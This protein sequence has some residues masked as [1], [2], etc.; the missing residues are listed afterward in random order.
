MSR[1][2][3]QL[4]EHARRKPRGR[5]ILVAA[6][7][8]IVLSALSMTAKANSLFDWIKLNGNPYV[9]AGLGQGSTVAAGQPAYQNISVDRKQDSAGAT[10][11]AG[12]R[13][14]QTAIE[15]GFMYLPEYHAT[16]S[17]QDYPAYKGCT[18]GP[19]CPQTASVTQDIFA[20]AFYLRGNLYTPPLGAFTGYG[21]AGRALVQNYNHEHGT[22]NG[23]EFV[24]F[25]VSFDNS[26]WLYGLGVEATLDKAWALRLEHTRI[27]AA[28]VEEHTLVRD[29]DFT[30]VNMIRRF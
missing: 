20:R 21:F 28:T 25:K 7:I 26:A 9:G 2:P 3:I 14:G 8:A 29:V 17:T 23:T 24:D 12:Y 10:V 6:L 30:S 13:F 27:P 5:R 18:L 1:L 22:Y 11:F 16:A 4:V 15:G 19:T